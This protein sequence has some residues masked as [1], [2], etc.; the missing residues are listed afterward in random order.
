MLKVMYTNLSI[1]ESANIADLEADPTKVMTSCEQLIFM[2][3]LKNNGIPFS[4]S[5]RGGKI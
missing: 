4:N 2:H 3:D 1:G 5:K